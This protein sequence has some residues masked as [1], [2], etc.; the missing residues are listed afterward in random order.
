M[1]E[2]ES[3]ATT[4]EYCEF[5]IQLLKKKKKKNTSQ[6]RLQIHVTIV[7]FYSA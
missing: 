4:I 6:L 5:S 2:E 3:E 7:G 1:E